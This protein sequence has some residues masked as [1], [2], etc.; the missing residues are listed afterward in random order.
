ME[1]HPIPE[2]SPVAELIDSEWIDD[3]TIDP[4]WASC[5]LIFFLFLQ[6]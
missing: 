1:R 2:N 5:E 3:V 4:V 6:D